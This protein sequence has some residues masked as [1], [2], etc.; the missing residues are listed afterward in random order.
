MLLAQFAN[1]LAEFIVFGHSP[2]YAILEMRIDWTA[3]YASVDPFF[4]NG[5]DLRD[6]ELLSILRAGRIPGVTSDT[7]TGVVWPPDISLTT[8]LVSHCTACHQTGMHLPACTLCP[9]AADGSLQ[10]PMQVAQLRHTLAYVVIWY[11]L[12]GRVHV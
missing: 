3:T 2:M 9:G 12:A 5:L 8:S 10:T 11:P 1:M 4:Q 6:N 7:N